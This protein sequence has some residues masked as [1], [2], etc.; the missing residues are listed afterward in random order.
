MKASLIKSLIVHKIRNGS[1]VDCP[2][3]LLGAPG[4]GKSDLIRQIAQEVADIL[5][6]RLLDVRAVL[7]DAVDTRGLPHVIT[8]EDGSKQTIW[9]PPGFLPTA[10]E[11]PGII[12]LDELSNAPQ[13]VQ[14][15]LL[16]LVL[17]RQLGEYVLPDGWIIIAAGNRVEDRS[18]SGRI[19]K[20]LCNR[21]GSHITFEVDADDWQSWARENNIDSRVR[22]FVNYRPELLHQFDPRDPE[23]AFA[24]PRSWAM[25]SKQLTD[26]PR[27]LVLPIAQSCVGEG[28][29]AEFFAFVQ[30]HDELPDLDAICSNPDGTDADLTAPA[31]LYALCG[32]LGARSKRNAKDGV[33]C[34]RY[35][36]RLP[37]EFG[38]LAFREIIGGGCKAVVK[39]PKV[40]EWLKNHRELLDLARGK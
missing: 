22:S 11:E 16:Q 20:S 15:A 19:L 4:V 35:A 13:L 36:T 21:F 7:L 25:L 3:M 5:P 31:A 39:D 14:S 30:V 26:A 38:A 2:T 10:D 23:P 8:L 12:F 32:A 6:G 37:T 29:A 27:E 40:V 34:A 1:A 18:G 24:S 17:D 9:V 33:A 28:A